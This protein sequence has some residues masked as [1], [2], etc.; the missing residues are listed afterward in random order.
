MSLERVMGELKGCSISIE[1]QDNMLFSKVREG[2]RNELS[3]VASVYFVQRENAFRLYFMAEPAHFERY[4]SRVKRTV[5]GSEIIDN[6]NTT[7]PPTQE[8]ALFGA[9]VECSNHEGVANVFKALYGLPFT[10][11]Q[12][13]SQKEEIVKSQD[14]DPDTITAQSL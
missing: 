1:Q 6:I 4:A 5:L 9:Y 2:K 12:G 11:I 7:I 10:P 8:V 13:L 3:T 14:P